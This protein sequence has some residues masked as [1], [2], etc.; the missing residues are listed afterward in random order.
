MIVKADLSKYKRNNT[1]YIHCYCKRIEQVIN[2][3]N[4]LG[5]K[6]QNNTLI[7]VILK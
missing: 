3:K 2:K 5:K 7:F 1:T 6:T 4:L